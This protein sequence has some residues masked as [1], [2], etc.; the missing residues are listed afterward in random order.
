MKSFKKFVAAATLLAL[1]T[2]P[3]MAQNR[4][5]V[6]DMQKLFNNYWKKSTAQAA[7]DNHKAE[8]AKE[9]KELSDGLDKAQTE[10]KALVAAANDQTLSQAERDK[11]QAAAEAKR[12]SI[13]DS[14]DSLIRIQRQD[15]AQLTDQRERMS[16]DILNDIQKAVADQAK[17]KGYTLVLNTRAIESVV[18]TSGQDD[19]TADALKQLNAGAPIDVN[20]TTSAGSSSAQPDAAGNPTVS[21]P[22]TANP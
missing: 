5:A 19:I 14:R 17:A 11:N 15:E 20:Q 16:A 22:A 9:I 1:L 21:K 6:V 4:I 13:S 8:L 12:A 18:Y 10:Y 7:L 3:A 2:V